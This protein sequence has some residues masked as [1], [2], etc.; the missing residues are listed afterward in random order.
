MRAGHGVYV[1]GGREE[2]EGRGVPEGEST[3]C[4]GSDGC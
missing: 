4:R 3:L 1:R 2:E